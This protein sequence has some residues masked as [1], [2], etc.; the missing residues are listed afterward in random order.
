MSSKAL[1][2]KCVIVSLVGLGSA[3]V[4]K[5]RAADAS[6]TSAGSKATDTGKPVALADLRARETD[7]LGEMPVVA[8]DGTW[9]GAL[10]SKTK[11]TV[12][13]SDNDIYEIKADIGAQSS[14]ECTLF[15]TDLNAGL[16]LSAVLN[17]ARKSVHMLNVEAK[18]IE[19]LGNHVGMDVIGTYTTETKNGKAIGEIKIFILSGSDRGFVCFHDELGYSKTF[20]ASARSLAKSFELLHEPWQIEGIE[21]SRAEIDEHPVGFNQHYWVR[22]PNGVLL[23]MSRSL[24]THQSA[25]GELATEDEIIIEGLGPDNRVVSAQYQ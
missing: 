6:S 9:R 20:G 14:M 11:P 19:V 12:T 8:G 10:L 17:E 22:M 16:W 23:A 15:S 2:A 21:I 5:H 25:P 18:G 24:I 13:R 3:C 1:V 4:P 7:G